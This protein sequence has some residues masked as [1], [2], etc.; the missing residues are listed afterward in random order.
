MN[1]ADRNLPQATEAGMLMNRSAAGI[2]QHDT[3]KTL[4]DQAESGNAQRI[5]LGLDAIIVP[6]AR[7][8][9]SLDHAVTLAKAANCQLLVLCSQRL[10]G[11][12]AIE[13]LATRSFH[14]ATVIDLPPGYSH[15]L[16]KFTK[17]D[18]IKAELP[19]ECA[20]FT[21]DLSM[22]RNLGLVLAKMLGWRRVFFLDD[23]IRDIA[24]PD[25]Q[26]TVDMLGSFPAAG[27]WVSEYPDNS[28]VCHANRETGRPQ[29]VF[30]SG[31]ALAVDCTQ[32]I[33]FFPD[34]YNEDWLFFF[35]N[36]ARKQLA[37]SGLTATQ[38]TYY[39]F[40]NPKRAAWQEFGDVLAEGLYSLLHLSGSAKDAT[41]EYWNR[42]LEA[43]WSFLD[44]ILNRSRSAGQQVNAEMMAAVNAALECSRQINPELCARYVLSWRNDLADWKRR[45]ATIPAMPSV[46]KALAELGLAATALASTWKVMPHWGEAAIP[47]VTPG[48]VGIPRSDTLEWMAGDAFLSGPGTVSAAA[49]TTKPMP[50]VADESTAAPYEATASAYEVRRLQ[51][52]LRSTLR[53]LIE[54]VDL[55]SLRPATEHSP[56]S[57]AP[58]TPAL[59]EPAGP[60]PWGSRPA[61]EFVHS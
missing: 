21:T 29:D 57:D 61:T 20:Y 46:E 35:D 1:G 42:F 11:A 25:L 9:E 54:K 50:A 52:W 55:P 23:D 34:I 14:R 13:Y 28:I 30:V 38:L 60:A 17:L 58:A 12:E 6:G 53:G 4:T 31:A 27:M 22:K 56:P 40:A 5:P 45:M 26:T 36:V 43:R 48:A 19:S 2:R 10:D 15:A 44:G 39:P 49:R 16:L 59:G 33:G 18:S 3:H 37:N 8:A 51:G 24:Y 47:P 41:P 7:P 32:D